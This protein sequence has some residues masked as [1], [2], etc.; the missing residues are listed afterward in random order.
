MWQYKRQVLVITIIITINKINIFEH[1]EDKSSLM[2]V[3]VH[4]AIINIANC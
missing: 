2:K 1:Q 4:C 3:K